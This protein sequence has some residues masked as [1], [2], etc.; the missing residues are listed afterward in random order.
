MIPIP[1]RKRIISAPSKVRKWL[2]RLE[3]CVHYMNM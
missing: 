2:R 1:Q 3:L